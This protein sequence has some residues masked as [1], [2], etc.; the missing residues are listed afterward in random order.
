MG[1]LHTS[2]YT[3]RRSSSTPSARYGSHLAF[4]RALEL[5][6]L[7]VELVLDSTVHVLHISSPTRANRSEER[8]HQTHP[9]EHRNGNHGVRVVGP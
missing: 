1:L 2:K 7:L 9:T 3:A 4:K 8:Q 5:L 6:L